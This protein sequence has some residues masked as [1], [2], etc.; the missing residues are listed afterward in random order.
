MANYDDD[1]NRIQVAIRIR[2]R[3][4]KSGE[5]LNIDEIDTAETLNVIFQA[6][7]ALTAAGNYM[8][9]SYCELDGDQIISND[10]IV[11]SIMTSVTAYI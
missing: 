5:K 1:D 11:G 2:P 10:S 4:E 3:Q 7:A 9:S 6:S 8:I